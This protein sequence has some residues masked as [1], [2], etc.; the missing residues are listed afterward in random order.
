MDYN[1]DDLSKIIFTQKELETIHKD[2]I[3][4]VEKLKKQRLKKDPNSSSVLEREN[5]RNSTVHQNT[6]TFDEDFLFTEHNL[7]T[8]EDQK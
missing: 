1:R 2:Y 6:T 4:R 5:P 3:T 8:K 7:D